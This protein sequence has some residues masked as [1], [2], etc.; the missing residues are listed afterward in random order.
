MKRVSFIPGVDGMSGILA[1]RAGKL[2][3]P[4]N[5]NKAFDAPDGRQYARNYGSRIVLAQRVKDGKA[6]FMVKT[7]SA[8]NMN[9]AARR[10]Q[11]AL[12]CVMSLISSL[13]SND[14]TAVIDG[15][16]YG[17]PYG[18]VLKRGF[19]TMPDEN[20][21]LPGQ[22]FEQW[23]KD[24]LLNMFYTKR[25]SISVKFKLNP[26]ISAYHTGVIA[27]PFG[28]ESEQSS[29]FFPWIAQGLYNKFVGYL[30][31]DDVVIINSQAFPCDNGDEWSVLIAAG[32]AQGTP[33]NRKELLARLTNNASS[34]VLLDGLIVYGNG[35]AVETDDVIDSETK[36][37]STPPAGA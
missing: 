28:M 1:G 18:S 32:V 24:L 23:V 12:G 35:T 5:D 21:V 15:I 2:V 11:A 30:A 16:N 25:A 13:K 31:I 29:A 9:D 37:T 34:Q 20:G 17:G 10:R 3:Y 27:N 4:S 14:C 7:K 26:L 36:Y 22:T 6:Y 33:I 19:D 8:V